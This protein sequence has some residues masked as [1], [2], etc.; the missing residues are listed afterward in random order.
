MFLSLYIYIYIYSSLKCS[1]Y[2][3]YSVYKFENNYYIHLPITKSNYY[4]NYF[5]NPINYA[6]SSYLS[7]IFLVK[8]II[9]NKIL[10]VSIT[11][12]SLFILLLS[13]IVKNDLINC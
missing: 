13:N 8:L 2:D 5:S 4:Y 12:L 9:N 1:K 10:Y 11:S 3:V 7:I 6:V